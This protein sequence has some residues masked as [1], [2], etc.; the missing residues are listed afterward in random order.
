MILPE[1]VNAYSFGLI[2]MGSRK[3]EA[4]VEAGGTG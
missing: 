3:A 4:M 2:V 1:S